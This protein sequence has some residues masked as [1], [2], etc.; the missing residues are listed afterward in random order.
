MKSTPKIKVCGLTKPQQIQ[1]ISEWGVDYF[2]FIFYPKSPR[3]LLDFMTLETLGNIN[4]SQKVGVFVNEEIETIENIIKTANL[5]LIQLHGDETPDD[6]IELKSKTEA[7]LIKVIKIGEKTS[8]SEIQSQLNLF[9]KSTDYYLFDT[10]TPQYGG[11][12]KTFNWQLLNQLHCPHPYFLAGGISISNKNELENLKSSPY[13]LDLNSKFENAP[14][15]KNT[16][17][18]KTFIKNKN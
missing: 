17:L 4:V 12:G 6:L 8:A 15:D 1:L 13:A 11:A 10:Q 7:D 3:Y 18:I 9:E 16:E 5:Q 2:G 14:G